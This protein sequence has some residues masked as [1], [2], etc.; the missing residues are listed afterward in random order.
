MLNS[1]SYLK[2]HNIMP[3]ISFKDGQP[4]I[5]KLIKDK[6]DFTLNDKGEKVE[7]MT[8]LVVEKGENKT[9]FTGSDSLIQKLSEIPENTEVQIQMISKK[10]PNGFIS[11]FEVKIPGQEDE[12]RNDEGFKET[13]KSDDIDYPESEADQIPF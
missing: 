8:Y 1:K 11:F 12:G 9:F 10:G 6:V 7:G 2:T 3:K 4:H 13:Q 5:V